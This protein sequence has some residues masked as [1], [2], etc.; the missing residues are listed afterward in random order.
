[1]WGDRWYIRRPQPTSGDADLPTMD[2]YLETGAEAETEA[3]A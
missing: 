3:D 1:M 2:D